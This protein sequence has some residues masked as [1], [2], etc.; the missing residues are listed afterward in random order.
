LPPPPEIVPS[1]VGLEGAPGVEEG[2][3]GFEEF[4]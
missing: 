3:E 2:E 4:G 1:K